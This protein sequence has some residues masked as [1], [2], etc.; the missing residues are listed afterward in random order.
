MKITILVDDMESWFVKYA[1][2]LEKSLSEK[3]QVSLIYDSK[4]AVDGDVCF[5]LSCSKIV[6]SDFLQKHRH[7]IVVHAS[8]LPKGKGFSPLSYQIMEGKDEI[9]LTLFEAIEELDAGP[10]YLKENLRFDGTELLSELRDL[11]AI[12]INQ[13]CTFFVEH[14]NELEPKPQ[15]GE[16]TMYKRLTRKDNSIDINKSIKEQFNHLR[17]ADNERYPLWFEYKN[18]KYIIHIYKGEDDEKK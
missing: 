10:Y 6:S 12:K 5:L 8:D 13:M 11:M 18:T 2:E 3:Y 17:I 14:I 15:V 9:V 7:N 1:K 4:K 16:E